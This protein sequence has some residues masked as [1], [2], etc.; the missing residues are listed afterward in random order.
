VRVISEKALKEF[1]QKHAQASAPLSSWYK[2]IRTGTFKNLAELKR[3]FASAEL[4]KAN[5]RDFH[6]FN[7]AGN[8]YRLIA[9]IHFNRQKLFV[10]HILTHADYDKGDWKK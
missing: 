9:A 7:V 1:G 10:R 5:G 2:L 6:V 4:V 3:T 8:N